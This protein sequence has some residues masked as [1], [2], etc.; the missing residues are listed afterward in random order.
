MQAC[1]LWSQE[2]EDQSELKQ[3]TDARLQVSR[4]NSKLE[5]TVLRAERE[6]VG[7]NAN[8]VETVE[9]RFKVAY[10]QLKEVEACLNSFR[11]VLNDTCEDL[12]LLKKELD[13]V[14]DYNDEFKRENVSIRY[15]EVQ[16]RANKLKKEIGKIDVELEHPDEVEEEH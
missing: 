4:A 1:N 9:A 13:E 7:L 12:Q 11:P 3:C 6:A 10:E 5:E 14:V 8:L 2:T 16:K 15:G